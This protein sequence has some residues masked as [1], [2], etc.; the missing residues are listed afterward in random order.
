MP[1]KVIDE[2]I[3]GFENG[4]FFIRD[5][6]SRNIA[7]IVEHIYPI[8]QSEFVE[9]VPENGKATVLDAIQD[10]REVAKKQYHL[11]LKMDGNPKY[12]NGPKSNYCGFVILDVRSLDD[13]YATRNEHLVKEK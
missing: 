4:D 9:M 6:N 7:K 11:V 12:S 13:H 2:I 1:F 3:I 5:S 10:V 8:S